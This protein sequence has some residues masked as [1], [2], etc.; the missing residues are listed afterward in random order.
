[1]GEK[2]KGGHMQKSPKGEKELFL[3]KFI[4]YISPQILINESSGHKTGH[5]KKH[6]L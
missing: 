2:E 5:D 4:V 1:M 6:Q 3:L